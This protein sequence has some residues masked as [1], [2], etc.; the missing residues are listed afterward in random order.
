MLAAKYHQ[1]DQEPIKDLYSDAGTSA[2]WYIHQLLNSISKTIKSASYHIDA[3]LL[4][5]TDCLSIGIEKY[6]IL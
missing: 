3:M 5:D 1:I 6:K 4:E 2:Y